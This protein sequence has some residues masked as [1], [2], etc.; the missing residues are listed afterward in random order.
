M[1]IPTRKS[2]PINTLYDNMKFKE[3][4]II[5]FNISIVLS[6]LDPNYR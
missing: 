6:E 4:L 3:L 2:E 5:I 1:D